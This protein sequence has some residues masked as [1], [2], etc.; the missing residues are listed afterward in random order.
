M[1]LKFCYNYFF[2][3]I[4]FGNENFGMEADGCTAMER[5]L[6]FSQNVAF[7]VLYTF[8]TA[9]FLRNASCVGLDSCFLIFYHT[10]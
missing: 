6:K 10:F 1:I 3:L 5:F 4:M 2:E 9:S 7:S 8:V